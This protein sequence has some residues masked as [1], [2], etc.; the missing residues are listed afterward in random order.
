M[1]AK[2]FTIG[3]DLA[4][5]S[6]YSALAIIEQTTLAGAFD[7]V[8]YSRPTSTICDLRYLRRFPRGTAYPDIVGTLHE[9]LHHRKIHRRA[10]L[11]CDATGLGGPVVDML[12]RAGLDAP[13]VPI[14]LT[15]SQ[16]P[17]KP[18]SRSVPKTDLIAAL[19]YRLHSK[20]LRIPPGLPYVDLL[21]NE[22]HH[23]RAKLSHE[24]RTRLEARRATDHDDLVIA[25]A[26][27]C[28]HTRPR[29]LAGHQPNRL[30]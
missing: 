4:Q 27:A 11:V 6:D 25:L 22:L 13:I 15:G 3:L 10:N 16:A 9:L 20:T 21:Y 5:S 19:S 14:I 28:W 12:T 26:L 18:D 2:P 7:H 30:L 1:L 29:P 24:G 17:A 23:F 8:T